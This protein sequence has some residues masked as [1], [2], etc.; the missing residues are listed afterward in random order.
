L[1]Y[2]G[3][4]VTGSNWEGRFWTDDLY[5][6]LG[7]QA[8]K[9][10]TDKAKDPGEQGSRGCPGEKK[11]ETGP[12][13]EKNPRVL[14]MPCGV[15][16]ARRKPSMSAKEKKFRRG[17]AIELN[18]EDLA[19][20]TE[21]LKLGGFLPRGRH[22]TDLKKVNGPLIEDQQQKKQGKREESKNNYTGRE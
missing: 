8:K 22:T 11:R 18:T 9:K 19:D 14:K 13:C 12:N 7:F 16:T 3:K 21:L 4:R 1:N 10:E 5:R 20:K 17:G 15:K 2:I 6:R